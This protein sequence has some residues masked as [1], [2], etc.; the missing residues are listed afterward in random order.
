MISTF[1]TFG[2]WFAQVPATVPDSPPN[3]A[4]TPGGPRKLALLIGVKDYPA[5]TAREFRQIHGATNDVA[6]MAA[7]LR[8]QFDFAPEDIR[9]LTD[10][11][12]TLG[13]VL[14][15]FA[16]WLIPTAKSGDVVFIYFSGHGSVIRNLAPAAQGSE[17]I[18]D[19][20]LVLWD[21]RLDGADGERDLTDDQLQ[22]FIAPLVERGAHVCVVTDACHSEGVT[23]GGGQSTPVRMA[24]E[25]TKGVGV[26][27]LP[28][29]WPSEISFLEDGDERRARPDA[30][31]H[32]AAC[33][34][35]EPAQEWIPK[36]GGEPAARGVFSMLLV[37]VMRE[38]ARHPERWTY[39]DLHRG[40]MYRFKAYRVALD[41]EQNPSPDGHIE[42]LVFSGA[43]RKPPGRFV[44]RALSSERIEFEAGS[45]AGLEVGTELVVFEK[46]GARIGVA[47]IDACDAVSSAG[48]WIESEPVDVDGTVYADWHG[49][50]PSLGRIVIQDPHGDAERF[51]GKTD[52][53]TFD[54]TPRYLALNGSVSPS[55]AF[56][57]RNQLRV[58]SPDG[59]VIVDEEIGPP[60]ASDA[61]V[62]ATT[63]ERVLGLLRDELSYQQLVQ[64]I[65]RNSDVRVS[66]T[67][68][69]PN[70]EELGRSWKNVD[71]M[72]P[73]VATQVGL[74]PEYAAS[75][76]RRWNQKH[77]G[78]IDVVNDDQDP[79]YVYVL[80]LMPDHSRALIYPPNGGLADEPPLEP[81]APPRSIYFTV[82]VPDT[83][84]QSSVYDDEYL[85]LTSTVRIDVRALLRRETMRGGFDDEDVPPF[86]REACRGERLR[87]NSP[88]APK[89]RAGTTGFRLAIRLNDQN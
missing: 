79:L 42:Q 43:Y 54:R 36:E 9:A 60:Q 50:P 75:H 2:L 86:L 28:D 26:E 66:V 13:N 56:P 30:Y 15:E 19:S 10:R 32:L 44:A 5:A 67:L 85:V 4:P 41:H 31:V 87:G 64:L 35:D 45:I 52:F 57:N 55:S 70:A 8:E 69:S 27:S 21:S 74:E 16:T 77:L 89:T 20:S 18:G 6:A 23:R 40:V 1:L 63:R 71:V 49:A 62:L 76:D 3:R 84:P 73:L 14:R 53:I 83:W 22:S 46:S 25:G 78:V 47:R 88:A 29:E 59:I 81:G 39:E 38:V 68:R 61:S 33:R 82:D 48:R 72:T 12:A 51:L 37:E 34:K 7:T 65:G 58:V 11:D 80:S 17:W 24:P